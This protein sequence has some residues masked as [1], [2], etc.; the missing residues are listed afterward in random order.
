MI[1]RRG[2]DRIADFGG[3]QQVAPLLA[4]LFLISGLAGLSLPGL[5]SFVSEFLVPLGTSPG[6]GGR[7][8]RHR[9]IVLASVYILCTYQ[10]AMGGRS[11]TRSRG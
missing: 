7:G 2:S 11:V 9:D 10:W 8:V 3:V 6:Q 1:I 5:G 4:G